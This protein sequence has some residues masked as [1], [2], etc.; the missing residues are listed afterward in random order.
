MLNRFSAACAVLVLMICCHANAVT[1]SGKIKSLKGKPLTITELNARRAEL[2]QPAITANEYR[3]SLRI[4]ATPRGENSTVGRITFDPATAVFAIDI[5]AVDPDDQRINI[6]FSG[7]GF[8]PAILEGLSIEGQSVNVIMPLQRYPSYR[9]G[10]AKKS[11][12]R[13]SRRPCVGR[14]R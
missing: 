8:Q 6:S 14:H 4:V 9:C 2:G 1:I 3:L 11:C 5:P 7:R 12:G 13:P 10:R